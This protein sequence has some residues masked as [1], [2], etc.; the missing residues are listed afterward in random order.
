MCTLSYIPKKDKDFLITSNRDELI[1]RKPAIFPSYMQSISGKVIFPKDGDAGGSWIAASKD[2]VVCLLNGAYEIHQRRD[3]YVLSRGLVV[4]EAFQYAWAEEFIENF[5]FLGIEA[6]TMILIEINSRKITEFV[7]DESDKYLRF[8]KYDEP[9]L[10][11]SVPLYT[12]EER[13]EKKRMFLEY[14]KKNSQ[15]KPG[16]MRQFH[17]FEGDGEKPAFFLS[18]SEVINTV[19]I[20]SVYTQ[21][22]EVKMEY[23][24]I[25]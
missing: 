20:T 6:F 11:S 18:R 25:G 4:L 7:W 21:D 15:P 22:A 9:H 16:Q 13:R 19:S 14:L 12:E 8:P 2:M 17:R 10:W 24:K 23:E 3:D 5:D 1:S